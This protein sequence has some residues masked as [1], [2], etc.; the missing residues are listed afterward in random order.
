MTQQPAAFLFGASGD[1]GRAIA[2]DLIGSGHRVALT[3]HA[4]EKPVRELLDRAEQLGVAA[5]GSRCDTRDPA[6]IRSAYERF[7][8]TLGPPAV[9]I[10]SAGV[11]RDR[12]LLQMTDDEW[13]DV[14]DTNLGGAMQSVRLAAADMVRGRNGSIIL[15][16]SVSGRAGVAGQ[17]NYAASKGGMDAMVRALTREFGQFGVTINAVAP[18]LVQSSMTA[19]LPAG[20]MRG[21]LSRIPLR[22][23][24]QPSDI[25]PLV[26]FLASDRARY[27]TGQTFV[28]DGGLT[29]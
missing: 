27:I 5:V 8:E 23:F 7:V 14:L 22:R 24:A 20:V 15:I 13:T 18:G 1:I 6:A 25:A 29:A 21:Y 3:Y 2:A 28:V 4:N 10:Y 26:T 16:S 9:L 17:A 11:R 12:G 19:D